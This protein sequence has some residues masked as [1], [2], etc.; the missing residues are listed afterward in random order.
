MNDVLLQS[1]TS[2]QR[3]Q[4]HMISKQYS[5]NVFAKEQCGKI[6]YTVEVDM[7]INPCDQNRSLLLTCLRG[8]PQDVNFSEDNCNAYKI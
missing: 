3:K 4:R 7:K 8:H 2:E 6:M 5:D 1:Y